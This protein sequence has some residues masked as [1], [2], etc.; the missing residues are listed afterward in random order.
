MP[1]MC[2]LTVYTHGRQCIWGSNSW[3]DRCHS[4]LAVKERGL[5]YETVELEQISHSPNQTHW[6]PPSHVWDLPPIFPIPSHPLVH[7]H[8]RVPIEAWILSHYYGIRIPNI[9]DPHFPDDFTGLAV[10][11]TSALSTHDLSSGGW[12][13]GPDDLGWLEYRKMIVFT[14]SC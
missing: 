4:G 1:V 14:N 9:C 7:P 13:L 12:G 3:S 11:S 2:L 8:L 5:T 6:L 10:L